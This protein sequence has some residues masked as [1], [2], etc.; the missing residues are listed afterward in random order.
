MD[1]FV[2]PW[3]IPMA[4][5]P[6]ERGAL[7]ASQGR[8]RAVGPASLL[9]RDFPEARRVELDGCA[10]L[11]ALVNAH[12][13]LELTLLGSSEARGDFA[14]WVLDLVRR[15]R[16]AAPAIYP[17]GIQEGARLCATRGQGV[18]GDI[19]TAPEAAADYPAA[20][21]QI[22]VFPEVI[23]PQESAVRGALERA[24]SAKP[25]PGG[26]ASVAGLSP[27]APYTVCAA[28]YQA[29]FAEA[30]RTEGLLVTHVAESPEELEFCLH[31]RGA[32][33]DRVYAGL[34][35]APPPPPK[36]H[37]FE[38][39]DGLGVIGRR[40]ILVHA[41]ALRPR[42]VER[43]AGLGAGVVLCPRSNRHLGVG[44]APGRAFLDAGVSVALG[45]D[46][47]LSSGDLDLWKDLV[48]SVEDYGWRPQEALRAATIG[49]ARVL[50]LGGEVGA[51]A[52]GRRADILAASLGAGRDL[53]EGI[54]AE[55]RPVGLWIE[56]AEFSL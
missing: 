33:V 29:C 36:T 51:F 38:W 43:I 56:G 6:I 41:V 19:L 37:P 23:A 46:S 18:V 1:L 26:R 7:A 9:A 31:G 3:V 42:H 54:L 12:A 15:K 11:P 49:G 25:R 35:A 50:G 53:Y 52:P 13:H 30:V 40:T 4:G 22:L 16:T 47:V 21:P 20:G 27:H 5:P 24:A 45:T 2:A 10:L 44:R 14:G 17:K 28:G 48:C 39:L 32:L 34:N 8:I 55:S